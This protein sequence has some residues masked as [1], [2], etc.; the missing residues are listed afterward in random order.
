MEI[1]FNGSLYV[2]GGAC[3]SDVSDFSRLL[4]IYDSSP[5]LWITFP[6]DILLNL[7][8]G[9]ILNLNIHTSK[10]KYFCFYKKYLIEY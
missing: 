1:K 10:N 3:M 7:S 5:T 8:L 9:S 4:H 2:V 6:F